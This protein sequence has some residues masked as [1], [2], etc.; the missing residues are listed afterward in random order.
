MHS[1]NAWNT[2]TITEKLYE[3]DLSFLGKECL[4]ELKT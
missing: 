4:W 2:Q 1:E 3:Y